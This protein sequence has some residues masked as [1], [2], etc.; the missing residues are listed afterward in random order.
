V[1]ANILKRVAIQTLV[2]FTVIGENGQTGV[3][4]M[5]NVMVVAA[6]GPESATIHPQCTVAMS[7]QWMF[8]EQLMKSLVTLMNVM[9]MV[10]GA[11][12]QKNGQIAQYRVQV[13]LCIKAGSVK[14]K[15]VKEKTVQDFL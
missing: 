12:G 14:I 1:V 10:Y 8:M 7:A 13:D 15:Q 9:L 2:Q 6:R 5:L 11:V 4:V 3:I